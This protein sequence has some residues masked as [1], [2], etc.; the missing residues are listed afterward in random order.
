[1]DGSIPPDFDGV[2]VAG[3][4]ALERKIDQLVKLM[5]ENVNLQRIAEL[6]SGMV[7]RFGHMG[8]EVQLALPEAQRDYL[9]RAILSHRTFYESRQLG[10]LYARR[11]VTPGTTVCDVGANIGNHS[12]YF[13][14][15]LKAGKVVAFEPQA[16]AFATL[17]RNLH[18]N[19]IDAGRAVN[20]MVGPVEGHGRLMNFNPSN[21]G[22]TTYRSDPTGDVPMVALDEA[23]SLE[24]RARLS[25]IKID[26][27]GM[28]KDVLW[29]ATELL[30]RYRPAIWVG[31]VPRTRALALIKEFLAPFGYTPEALSPNDHLFTAP[32]AG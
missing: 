27:E 14:T 4:R 32:P 10:L 6:E 12:V 2:Q 13:G 23:L 17:Q 20:A 5:G 25:L 24:E 29:G 1:M 19:G 26:V 30:G 11:I 28:E 8:H 18:L 3:T 21:H 9:Q 15:V 22:A 7:C 31:T 16:A